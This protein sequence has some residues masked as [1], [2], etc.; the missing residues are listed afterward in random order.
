MGLGGATKAEPAMR[1][2]ARFIDTVLMIVVGIPIAIILGGAAIAT[3]TDDSVGIGVGILGGVVSL[4][5]AGAYEG[6]MLANR[7]QTLGKMAVGIKVVRLDGQPL[8]LQGALTRHSPSLGLRALAVIP[9][10]GL[11]GSLG[12]AILAIVNIVM[13]F[14]NGESVYDKVGGTQVISAK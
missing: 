10:I 14:S 11:L 8:D 9:V 3:G 2:L 13:V 7:G 4:L 6:L 12:L 5:I 1:L